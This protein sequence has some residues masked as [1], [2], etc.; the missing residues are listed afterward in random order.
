[1]LEN[2]ANAVLLV[3]ARVKVGATKEAGHLLSNEWAHDLHAYSY[4]QQLRSNHSAMTGSFHV[5]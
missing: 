5:R 4:I 2:L 3:G 1:M